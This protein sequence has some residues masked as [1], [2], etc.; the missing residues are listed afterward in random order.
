[1]ADPESEQQMFLATLRR[2]NAETEKF[3]SEQRKLAAEADKFGRERLTLVISSTAA[4]TLAV[5]AVGGLFIKW[6]GG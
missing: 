4:L 2:M 1:M 6:I 5:A 3:V